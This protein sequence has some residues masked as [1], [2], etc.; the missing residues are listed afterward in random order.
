MTLLFPRRVHA[1][2]SESQKAVGAVPLL[3]E[4]T[5]SPLPDTT[6]AAA[7]C[8]LKLTHLHASDA[9]AVLAVPGHLA[10]L[11]ALLDPEAAAERAAAGEGPGFNA[12]LA[13]LLLLAAA[14]AAEAQP[15]L[16]R[17]EGGVLRSA[18][19]ACLAAARD[20][21]LARRWG[22]LLRAGAG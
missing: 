18:V 1:G 14:A 20:P 3:L 6:L 2:P 9:A 5:G 19:G 21:G 7:H 15:G 4:L 16:L 22:K 11:C 10:L 17:E 13:P 8:L 12:D